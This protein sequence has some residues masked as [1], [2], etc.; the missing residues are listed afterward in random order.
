M[1]LVIGIETSSA[2]TSVAV[3]RDGQVLGS[4]SHEDP[5]AHA[6]V[7]ARLYS[8]HVMPHVHGGGAVEAVVCGVGPG[9][10]SGLRVGVTFAQTLAFAWSVPAI[11]VCSLDA[12]AFADRDSH[13]ESDGPLGVSTDARRRE[14]YWA[15]YDAGVRI[16]G[17]RV[18]SE[19]EYDRAAHWITDEVPS[20]VA[21]AEYARFHGL[22]TPAPL[23]IDIDEHGSSGERTELALHGRK[24]LPPIPLYLRGADITVSHRAM[25]MGMDVVWT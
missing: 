23:V 11:G 8:E 9:P 4:G 20:A 22:T 5:R 24:L 12:I 15:I 25:R 3:L 7:I 16:M 13:R 6:E 18:S 19:P 10:Y 21:V 14:R 1:G 17:P 2:V